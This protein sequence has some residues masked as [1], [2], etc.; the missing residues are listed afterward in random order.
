[1][2]K[3]IKGKIHA[4]L[5]WQTRIGNILNS[6]YSLR[7]FLKNSFEESRLRN[8]ENFEAYLT[9]QYH[10]IEKGLALP[11]PRANFGKVKILRLIKIAKDYIAIYGESALSDSIMESLNSYL[12]KNESLIRVDPSFYETITDFVDSDKRDSTGGVI[13]V[14]KDT[15][16][17]A[18][19][20]DYLQFVKT[21]S[22]V[23]NYSAEPVSVDE[24]RK[25][26][27][28]A[29]NAPSVCNRQSWRLH[30][31]SDRNK[32]NKLLKIQNGNGGFTDSINK[33]L[34][35]SV[36]TQKFTKLEGNQV[37]VDG[38][39]FA[40]NLLLSLHSMNIGSCCLNTCLPYSDE[41]QIKLIGDIPKEERLIMMIGIGKLKQDYEVALSKKI[42]I[43]NILTEHND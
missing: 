34:V 8:K 5:F 4:I 39:L 24:I 10:I 36:D 14:R 35:V 1:M 21:R 2:I 15:I 38:G 25:A 26:V 9:K 3:K 12:N 18:T 41:N 11:K 17:K 22:S 30:Y 29:R 40:M 20:I 42:D 33:L 31:Y 6:T 28:I 16:Q 27:D 23:R 43:I 32:M 19:D 13:H 7:I 37:F